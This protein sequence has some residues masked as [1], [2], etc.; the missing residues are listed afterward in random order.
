MSLICHKHKHNYPHTYAYIKIKYI[1]LLPDSLLGMPRIASILCF[2]VQ[3]DFGCAAALFVEFSLLLCNEYLLRHA[4]AIASTTGSVCL[5]VWA[6]HIAET[7][8]Y[9][10]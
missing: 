8:R 3:F 6:W 1:G 10:M 9:G 2:Y 7:K 4:T 5:L